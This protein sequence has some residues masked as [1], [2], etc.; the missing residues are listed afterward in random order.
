MSVPSNSQS[1]AGKVA[2]VPG[3]TGGLGEAIAAEVGLELGAMLDRLLERLAR[4]LARR[5]VAG[6]V[7]EEQRG[8]LAALMP[9]SARSTRYTTTSVAAT[10]W[11]T[12]SAFIGKPVLDVTEETCEVLAVNLKAGCSSVSDGA[13]RQVAAKAAAS[14][15]TCSR[16]APNSACA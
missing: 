11:S 3:G 5:H 1:I 2:Y 9:S 13:R 7:L 14:R 4:L 10:S 6:R 12:A 15:F 8:G 16:Y